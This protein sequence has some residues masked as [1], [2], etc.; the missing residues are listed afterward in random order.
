MS[1]WCSIATYLPGRGRRPIM[2]GRGLDQW[3]T[4]HLVSVWVYHLPKRESGRHNLW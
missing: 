4:L 2:K 1:A 3:L